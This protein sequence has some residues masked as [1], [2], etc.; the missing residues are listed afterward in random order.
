MAVYTASGAN[1]GNINAIISALTDDLALKVEAIQASGASASHNTTSYAT[2]TSASVSVDLE[3]D[4]SVILAATIN[5]SA[6]NTGDTWVILPTIGASAGQEVYYKAPV[7]DS[8]GKVFPVT[9]WHIANN[10]TAGSATCKIEWKADSSPSGS[11]YSDSRK[12]VVI[13]GKRRA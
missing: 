1:T 4:S 10:Q 9:I 2:P 8:S 11:I 13:Q 6:D 12:L 7:A 5:I 3:S